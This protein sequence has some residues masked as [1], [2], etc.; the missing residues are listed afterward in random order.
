MI[1]LSRHYSML[2][3]LSSADWSRD[4]ISSPSLGSSIATKKW[5]THP[6]TTLEYWDQ[7]AKKTTSFYTCRPTFGRCKYRVYS[8]N[9]W[10]N[11]RAPVVWNLTLFGWQHSWRP[12]YKMVAV[13]SRHT[14]FSIATFEVTCKLLYDVRTTGA[15][16]YRYLIPDHRTVWKSRLATVV[17]TFGA[18]APFKHLIIRNREIM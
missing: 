14:V 3:G 17:I 16:T 6:V 18:I 9:L 12:V 1:L 4:D 2:G 10:E 11:I 5:R 15:V 13:V 8:E 7:L